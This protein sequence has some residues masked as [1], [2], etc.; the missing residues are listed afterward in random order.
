MGPIEGQDDLKNMISP[1]SSN[2]NQNVKE[3][4]NERSLNLSKLEQLNQLAN[5][6]TSEST[7]AIEP[8]FFLFYWYTSTVTTT[9][10]S[11][12]TTKTFTLTL[13]TPAAGF[14]YS[15]CG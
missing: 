11:F 9:T 6:K 13:C 8:R 5:V 2:A 15:A 12:S 4:R 3:A 7:D 10:T 14:S 1:S